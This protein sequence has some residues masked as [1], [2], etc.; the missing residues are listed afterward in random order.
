VVL[1]VAGGLWPAAG[2]AAAGDHGC[3]AKRTRVVVASS[4]IRVLKRTGGGDEGSVYGCL[5]KTGEWVRLG[6]DLGGSR[7]YPVRVTEAL[8]AYGSYCACPATSPTVVV[9]DLRRH[10]LGLVDRQLESRPTDMVLAPDG[11]V[12]WIEGSTPRFPVWK[13]DGD[14]AAKVDDGDEVAPESLALSSR[15]VYWTRAGEPYSTRLAE[16]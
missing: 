14:G 10:G 3:S 16:R 5:L 12:A 6:R 1:V 13:S 11:A 2:D 8:V 9:R 4:R 15:I 7:V